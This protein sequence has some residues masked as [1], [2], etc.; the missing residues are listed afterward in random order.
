MTEV[1]SLPSNWEGDWGETSDFL[2]V[3][4]VLLVMAFLDLVFLFVVH[5]T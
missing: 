1:A 3:M 4:V 5:G 2:L